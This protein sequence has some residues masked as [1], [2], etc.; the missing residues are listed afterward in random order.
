VKDGL[1]GG[2]NEARPFG[3]QVADLNFGDSS[4]PA[5]WSVTT[6]RLDFRD[7]RQPVSNII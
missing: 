2:E 6:R 1:L 7:A 3:S 4:R 5:G